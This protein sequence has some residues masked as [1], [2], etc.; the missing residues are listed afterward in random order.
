MASDAQ[1]SD[2]YGEAS[3][4]SGDYAIVGSPYED[5]GGSAA[6]AAYIYKRGLQ[7]NPDFTTNSTLHTN[8]STR[9]GWSTNSGWVVDASSEFNSSFAPWYA[10]NKKHTTDDAWTSGAAPSTSSPQWLRIKYPS[11][12]LLYTSPS[13]RD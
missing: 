8:Y 12:C 1:A 7:E 9:Y 10:F 11:A 13:P 5:A 3:S 6:G 4:I 2:Q